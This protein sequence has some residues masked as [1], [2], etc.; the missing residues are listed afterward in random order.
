MYSSFCVRLSAYTTVSALH[1]MHSHEQT[2]LQ[3]IRLRILPTLRVP[4]RGDELEDLVTLERRVLV[5]LDM[6]P[7][8]NVADELLAV[9]Y[10]LFLSL[11][12][13]S[14]NAMIKKGTAPYTFSSA[15]S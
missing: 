9:R 8:S 7:R 6:V 13:T 5:S 14:I 15:R 4:E 1:E 11:V 2:N 10:A 3:P 12:D